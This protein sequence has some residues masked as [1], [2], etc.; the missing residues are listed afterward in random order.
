MVLAGVGVADAGV[1]LCSSV[2]GFTGAALLVI[3][4]GFI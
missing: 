3:G 4:D 1:V 2:G